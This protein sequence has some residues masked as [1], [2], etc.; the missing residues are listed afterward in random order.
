MTKVV[1]KL[2]LNNY[3][4]LVEHESWY[5]H[6][7]QQGLFLKKNGVFFTYFEKRPQR[8]MKY[9][10]EVS[11]KAMAIEQLDFY[12]EAGWDYVTS[13]NYFHVFSSPVELNAPEIHTDPTQQSHMLKEL[14]RLLMF[15]WIFTIFGAVF[16][17]TIFWAIFFLDGTPIRQLV[18]GM[19]TS[20]LLLPLFMFLLMIQVAQAALSIRRLKKNLERGIP[21]QHDIPWRKKTLKHVWACL[22]LVVAL[23]HLFLSSM[24][25]YMMERGTLTADH[26]EFSAVSL[27][28]IENNDAFIHEEHL[29][30]GID[31]GNMYE[32]A[33]NPFAPTQ[34]TVNESGIVPNLMWEDGSR[35]Y[36][37]SIMTEY[38]E[39]SFEFLAR[40]L[41]RD[42]MKWYD[43]GDGRLY[44]KVA[45]SRFDVLY[46]R[47][48]FPKLEIAAKKGKKVVYVRYYGDAMKSQ[49]IEQVAR[50]LISDSE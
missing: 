31:Y 11:K 19:T 27:A 23:L 10:I 25:L 24:Q 20:Q 8:Q 42:L 30:N 26:H 4:N 5:T 32:K 37:P 22:F 16:S 33:W 40:P 15:N 39:V 9:R 6:M 35:K 38:Y 29:G 7:A 48:D 41:A 12:E 13:Y 14:N 18:K 47:E 49:V 28:S 2:R 44:S 46:T 1:R 17:S 34:Y 45:D 43:F 50:L 3:W 36:S 21:L